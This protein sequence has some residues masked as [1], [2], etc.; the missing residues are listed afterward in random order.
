MRVRLDVPVRM[1]DDVELAADI[2]LPEDAGPWPV[3]LCRTPYDRQ[4]RQY[5]DWA[6]R[7]VEARYAAVI[8]DCRGRYASGGDWEAYVHEEADGAATLRWLAEQEFCD[9][10]VGMF[11]ISYVGFVQS[12]AATQ[13]LSQLKAIVPAASQEDNFGH[14]WTDG[15]L[16]L[17]NL[18]NFAFYVGR[19]TMHAGT[20]A[21]YNLASA[22]RTLPLSDALEGIVP[23]QTYREFL[24]HPTFDSFWRRYS[25]KGRYGQIKC[26]ALLI[27]GWYDNLLAEQF[28]VLAGLRGEGG[29]AAA[30]AGSRVIIGPWSHFTLGARQ[31]AGVDFGD[32][33][34]RPLPDMH[35]DFYDRFLRDDG[36][37]APAAPYEFF[38]MGENVWRSG[39]TWPPRNCPTMRLYLHSDGHANS[40]ATGGRLTREPPGSQPPDRF[41]YDPREPVPTIGG[42]C[43]LEANSGPRDRS[44]V[45]S[46]S[47]VLIYET[48]P[49]S[50]PLEVSGP[51]EAEIHA[52]SSAADTDFT[53]TLV[54]VSPDGAA[55]TICEGIV[56]AR[57]RQ[58]T[59]TPGSI[60]P[61]QVERYRIS[62]WSTS[63]VFAAGHRLR[64]EISS[65]NF[66]R[67]DRNL[68][69]G[70]CTAAGERPVIA[71]QTV[72]HDADRPSCLIVAARER[73]DLR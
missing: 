52:A 50:R 56:R 12:L 13:S 37:A 57:Y 47:D 20:A 32:A 68:N 63:C 8:Q 69:S 18:V 7:F 67:F 34:V 64:L 60:G 17:E 5:V 39:D 45:A 30:R 33:A 3:A 10:N 11:G 46:R 49:L 25:L 73:P 9:G 26:P 22:Y 4:D 29:S 28:K 2:Y 53:A 72:Y 42:P 48:E 61:D 59:Q 15:V 14:M 66:P 58:S 31:C 51:V 16:Q 19:R 6:V 55:R 40:V 36:P 38:V 23:T 35:L 70:E 27:T 54:D 44:A 21:H 24:R 41:D 65:S 71:H 62:L 1:E 43:M